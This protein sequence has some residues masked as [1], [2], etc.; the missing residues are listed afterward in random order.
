MFLEN[1]MCKTYFVFAYKTEFGSRPDMDY[2][3]QAIDT[4]RDTEL[5][6]GAG[7]RGGGGGR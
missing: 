5:F 3:S 2:A 1:S 4:I 6:F 7:P